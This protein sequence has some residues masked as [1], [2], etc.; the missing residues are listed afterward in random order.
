MEET[1]VSNHS[2]WRTA[3]VCLAVGCVVM[4]IL[5]AETASF[6]VALT[7]GALVVL[8]L[9]LCRI[10]VVAVEQIFTFQWRFSL[11]TL[12]IVMTLVALLL[13]LMLWAAKN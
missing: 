13:G 11:R 12:L 7:I 1:K 8:I 6:M 4:V 9:S 2:G 3:L 10:T 5:L